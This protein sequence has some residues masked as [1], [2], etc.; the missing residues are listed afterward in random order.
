MG[1]ASLFPQEYE[2][3]ITDQ[4][5]AKNVKG[6][7]HD[8]YSAT[9]AG[10]IEQVVDTVDM[11]MEIAGQDILK[12]CG[13]DP[14]RYEQLRRVMRAAAVLHDI[15][16]LSEDFQAM[17]HDRSRTIQ[18][19][20]HEL[21]SY[22]LLDKHTG[23]RQAIES[24]LGDTSWGMLAV[25]C[26]ILGHHLKF[27]HLEQNN[28]SDGV[29]QNYIDRPCA[30]GL[31]QIIEETLCR[32]IE[33]KANLPQFLKR[34][35]EVED[36]Q[37]EVLFT[38]EE[39][40]NRLG[41]TERNL[42]AM[43]RGLLIAA[44]ALGSVK[45]LSRSDWLE[46]KRKS[47]RTVFTGTPLVTVLTE[48]IESKMSTVNQTSAEITF[49]QMAVENAG[50]H[51]ITIC[52]AG[53]G[54][55]KTIAAYRWAKRVNRPFLCFAYPTTATATQGYLD[56]ES[57]LGEVGK[58]LHH[59]RREVDFELLMNPA[60]DK[61]QTTSSEFP[62]LDHLLQP[63]TICTVDTIVGMTQLHYSSLC[64]LPNIVQSAIVF[65]EIHSYDDRLFEHVLK[66][67][68]IVR[69]PVL[70]M[71]A[72]LQPSRR[73]KLRELADEVAKEGRTTAWCQGPSQH[74]EIQRY[75]LHVTDQLPR[76]VLWE[77]L[78]QKKNVLIVVNTTGQAMKLY[79]GLRQEATKR[80]INTEWYCYHSRY[81]YEHR[82]HHQREVVHA[83]RT[84]KGVCA[85]TTQIAEMSFDVSC[86]LLLSEIAPF[87]AL[88]QRLGRL[89]RYAKQGDLP[90]RAFFW[91][92][93]TYHPYIKQE[94][95]LI[96][97]RELLEKSVDKALSQA[98]LAR[99]L[100]ECSDNR[101]KIRG[102]EFAWDVMPAS[103]SVAIRDEIDSVD[104]ILKSDYDYVMK[105]EPK[106]RAEML[107]YVFPI[108]MHDW[109][110][111]KQLEKWR[112]VYIVPDEKID[113]DMN[114]G[115]RWRN[116]ELGKI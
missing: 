38:L 98:D 103:K 88:I 22:W 8:I 20:R 58:K 27:I 107:K 99:L 60:S 72:S 94:Q 92:P 13:A 1:V 69:V 25:Q 6:L 50:D 39:Q 87:S 41:D 46:H 10:H 108:R 68:K 17:I 113:Y 101:G 45:S 23:L 47:I 55:G 63:V 30:D 37:S 62:A 59:S 32:P 84:K 26:A 75:R 81:K 105:S 4:L 19:V 96:R 73:H 77:A 116:A 70:L 91:M 34:R 18:P 71:T 3:M 64:V 21:I 56:Y 28:H 115:A 53:C 102:S 85:I 54:S 80:G 33:W 43:V 15:G 40:I 51:D 31:K 83:F 79:D 24:Y 112:Y 76:E 16:K 74:Q 106:S 89:N 49:F 36:Y 78:D 29:L 93:E 100:Q 111:L 52:E 65:D 57:H 90:K 12:V 66:F 82:L 35:V 95:Q 14:T 48:L 114:R 97:A 11:V 109:A 5:L 7:E 104:V 44:D 67:L 86:D 61:V 9:L 42:C 2:E 110:E